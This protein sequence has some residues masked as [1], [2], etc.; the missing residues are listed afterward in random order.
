M[1][2]KIHVHAF[3]FPK[4][5]VCILGKITDNCK[6]VGEIQGFRGLPPAAPGLSHRRINHS[7]YT[8]ETKCF[9]VVPKFSSVFPSCSFAFLSFP[10]AFPCFFLV[11]HW[12]SWLFLGFS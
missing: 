4:H 5:Y 9:L 11:V 8:K 3:G 7:K 10:L 1:G 12:F 2:G 6:Y